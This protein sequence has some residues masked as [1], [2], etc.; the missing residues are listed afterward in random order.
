MRARSA[1]RRHS[2]CDP[3]EDKRKAGT[4]ET[5]EADD[6]GQRWKPQFD[7]TPVTAEGLRKRNG[8]RTERES[9][10]VCACVRVSE[11]FS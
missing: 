11:T 5:G 6:D 3:R 9:V 1:S 2:R 7:W 8:C 10:C 4:F